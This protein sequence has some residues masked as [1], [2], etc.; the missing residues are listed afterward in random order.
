MSNQR[1]AGLSFNNLKVTHTSCEGHSVEKSIDLFE[2]YEDLPDKLRE[3]VLRY[4]V[5]LEESER[6]RV[7]L[8]EEF[9][10][11]VQEQ[12]YT[13]D[14]GLDFVPTGLMKMDLTMEDLPGEQGAARAPGPD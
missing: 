7:E 6:P 13:F 11:E 10:K 8:C 4:S 3:I 12:G 1:Q 9:L 14:Y 5:D 2:S